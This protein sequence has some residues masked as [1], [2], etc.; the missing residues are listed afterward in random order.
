[1]YYSLMALAFI[2]ASVAFF[3]VMGQIGRTKS[4]AKNILNLILRAVGAIFLMIAS[5]LSPAVSTEST[6]LTGAL[7]VLYLVLSIRAIVIFYRSKSSLK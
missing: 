3:G 7:A 2:A 5:M 1:M 4:P 6:C